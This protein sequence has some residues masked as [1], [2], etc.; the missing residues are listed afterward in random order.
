MLRMIARWFISR[1]IDEDVRPPNW[2]RHWIDRDEE[3]KQ[4]EITSRQL[5]SRLKSDAP[6]WIASQATGAAEETAGPQR[7]VAVTTNSSRRVRTVAW[8]LAASAIAAGALFAI[9]WLQSA[10]W[11]RNGDHVAQSLPGGD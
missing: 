4:F 11:Q 10:R 6:G 8:S 9:A 7:T 2:I 3:L 5:D 1:S